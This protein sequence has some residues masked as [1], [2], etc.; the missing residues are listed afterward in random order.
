M[1]LLLILC[2]ATA[3]IA[4]AVIRVSQRPRR[5]DGPEADYEDREN[6]WGSP[7]ADDH[8]PEPTRTR[9]IFLLLAWVSPAIPVLTVIVFCGLWTYGTQP[10][11][12]NA[13]DHDD[14]RG[15]GTTLI[16]AQF[17]GMALAAVSL[18]GIRCRRGTA[19]IL[20]GAILGLVL[21]VPCLVVAIMW[22]SFFGHR[23]PMV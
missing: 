12:K 7:D 13:L 19:V 16:V 2:L 21:N 17:V 20:P 5:P 22:T 15:I 6:D 3:A 18:A 23:G 11:K 10:G 9:T 8:V 1:G 14:Y 4:I